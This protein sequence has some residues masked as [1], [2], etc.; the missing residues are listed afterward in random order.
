MADTVT[1]HYGYVEVTGLV[2]YIVP[3]SSSTPHGPLLCS[4]HVSVLLDLLYTQKVGSAKQVLKFAVKDTIG[5]GVVERHHFEPFSV[6][7][8]VQEV[9]HLSTRTELK[10]LDQWYIE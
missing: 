3:P 5:T 6:R 7:A 4:Q 9:L 1:N 8:T 2:P 10:N